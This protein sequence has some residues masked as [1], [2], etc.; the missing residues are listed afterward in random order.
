MHL[1]V[2]N[3]G[4]TPFASKY[5]GVEYVFEPKQKITIDSD[6]A[7]H[8]FGVGL[9]D[10]TEILTRHGW[11]SHS[12]QMSSA[13]SRLDEFSFSIPNDNPDDEPVVELASLA[14]VVEDENEQ[15]SAPLQFGTGT[16]VELPDGDSVEVP[17]PISEPEQAQGG[18]ILD[19]LKKFIK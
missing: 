4:N 13:M 3:N 7:Q 19:S 14:P 1:S 2:C 9:A 16:E 12:S 18:S 17:A 5:N 15:G 8:I 10:K 6:A 11:M